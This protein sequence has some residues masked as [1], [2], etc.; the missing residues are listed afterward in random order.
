MH[1]RSQVSSLTVIFQFS[2]FS[3]SLSL[4]FNPPWPWVFPAP[5][6]ALSF[7]SM[8]I[9]TGLEPAWAGTLESLALLTFLLSWH[10]SC[11]DYSLNFFFFFFQ[12]QLSKLSS[13]VSKVCRLS[14]AWN[15]HW[16]SQQNFTEVS[17][18]FT[19]L[20]WAVCE[21]FQPLTTSQ[22]CSSVTA[23]FPEVT[24]C[25]HA[26]ENISSPA[27]PQSQIFLLSA[28]FCTF[29]IFVAWKC[30]SNW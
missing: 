18:H 13:Y 26:T 17:K 8:C 23:F 12:C 14:L 6:H 28:F 9:L 10:G 15:S 4:F 30:L 11:F 7:G 29:K 3:H 19:P 1:L 24:T 5:L 22:S 2:P 25:P 21:S 20:L 16:E 27:A